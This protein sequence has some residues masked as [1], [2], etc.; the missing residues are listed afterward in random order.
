MWFIYRKRTCCR[1][2]SVNEINPIFE[3]QLLTYMNLLNALIDCWLTFEKNIFY[4]GHKKSTV[5]N[6]KLED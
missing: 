2:E 6:S 5:S 1:I 3:A 4:E